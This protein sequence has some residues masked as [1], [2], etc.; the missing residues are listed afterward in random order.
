MWV[1]IVVGVAVVGCAVTGIL[2]AIAIPAFVGYVRRAKTAEA[3]SN[4]R[5]LRVTV[6]TY[7]GSESVVPGGGLAGRVAANGLPP[8][9]GPVP[10]T[11]GT[12][13]QAAAELFAADPG[14]SAIHFSLPDPLYYSYAIEPDGADAVRLVARGDLDGDGTQSVFQIRCTRT[15]DGCTCDPTPQVEQENE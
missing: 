14:F 4:L 5:S 6:E 10:P 15:T 3:R 8:A 7:C 11:P 12:E 9:A 1:L 13:K 2:A